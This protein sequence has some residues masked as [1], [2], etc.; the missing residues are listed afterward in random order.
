M[1]VN[2]KTKITLKGDGLIFHAV[3][4]NQL[5][6]K[7]L[8]SNLI[9]A[10]NFHFSASKA[11]CSLGC[12]TPAKASSS[13]MGKQV[14][15]TWPGKSWHHVVFMLIRAAFSQCFPHWIFHHL[16][17]S[18]AEVVLLNNQHHLEQS[19]RGKIS[20][21]LHGWFCSGFLWCWLCAGGKYQDHR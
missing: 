17:L 14:L 7:F 13:C 11:V 16:C 4:Q 9:P 10:Y 20:S 15:K 19:R 2:F 5:F 18:L 12:C 6:G 8:T 3:C 21:S 1:Q